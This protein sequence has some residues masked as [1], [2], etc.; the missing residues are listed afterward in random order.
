MA[1]PQNNLQLRSTVHAD[2]RLELNLV[3]VPL[4]QLGEEEVLVK[5][6][7]API[8]PS[9]L[10]L[11]LGPVDPATLV[12][13]GTPQHPVLT[14]TI[15]PKVLPSLAAR[16]GASMSVG[17]EGAGEVVAAGSSPRAQALLGKTVAVLGGAM[18]SQFIAVPADAA[19]V[20]PEGTTAAEGASALVN[21]LTALGMVE[22]MRREGHTALVHTAAA[23]SLGQM[24]VRLCLEEKVPLVN[25]V[26]KPEQAALLRELGATHV[27]D[28]SSPE[29][30][31]KLLEAIDAT[32]ATLGF[33]AIGGGPLAGQILAAME[34]S[35]SRKATRYNRYGSATHKQVYIYGALDLG[36]TTLPRT[37]GMAWGVGGWLVM[38]FLAR[39]G[40]EA[41]AGLKARVAAGL[42]TTFATQYAKEISLAQ[43]LDPEVARAYSQ[44]ATGAKYLINPS[45]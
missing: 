39:I 4:P 22:T 10:G 1:T 7:A 26:R 30:S 28:S 37:L 44:K 38:P 2:G 9:D 5:I 32:G 21:P 40:R 42:K 15:H 19:L 20:L 43:V 13:S 34:K 11:L 29:F 35:L 8:N 18:Y 45:R 17:N 14:G 31:A 3:S 6:T 33:D 12:A 25:V 41:A 16:V 23:S 27:V 24:L 36:P